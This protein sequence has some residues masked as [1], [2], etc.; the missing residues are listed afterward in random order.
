MNAKIKSISIENFKGAKKA[1][2]TFGDKT[3]IFGANAT[4]K[5]TIADAVWWLLFNKDSQ[6]NEKFSIRPLDSGGKQ[7]DNVEI[8]VTA[9]LDI[10]GKEMT[11]R[12][13][14][15]QNWV[16]KRGE[17]EAK[18]QGNVDSYEVDGYPKAEKDYKECV[19]QII[20]E[21]LFKILTSPTYFPNMKWQKQR[22]ILM[23]FVTDISDV[24]LARQD[25]QFSKLI[26]E[27]EKAPSTDDIKKKYQKSL[28]E[29]K[30]KQK[31]LPVRIDEAEKQKVDIDIAELELLKNSLNEQIAK[32]KASQEDISKQFEEQQKA[33]DGV[34]ELRF[35]LSDLVRK[36]NE[37]LFKKR[38]ELQS[39]IDEKNQ[40]LFDIRNGIQKNDR[41]IA[42]YEQDIE[43]GEKER[44]RLLEEWQRVKE[45]K[46]DENTAICPTCHRELPQEERASLLSA[47][48]KSKTE[49][50]AKIEKDGLEIKA[51]IENAKAMIPKLRNC[52]KENLANKEKLEKEVADLENRMKE[53][54][55]KADVSEDEEIKE[56]TQQIAEKEAAMNQSGTADEMREQIKA[57]GEDLQK[58]LIEVEKQLANAENNAK[59]DERIIELQAEQRE[60]AQKVA[61]QEKMLYLLEDF[62]RFK[63]DKVSDTIN[64][65]L[66]GICVKLFENQINGGIKECC[67]LTYDGVP[68]GSLNNGHRIVAGLKII[69]ALQELYGVYAPIFIDNAESVNDFNLPD[70]D[71]QMIFLSVPQLTQ[72][73]RLRMSPEEINEFYE[74]YKELRVEVG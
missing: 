27:L 24:E 35:K 67:E 10:D 31:E 43:S 32:N 29:W 68:Y 2:Y 55:E 25:E 56:I 62:I 9:V 72:F 46:F 58:Q 44:K 26:E 33:S 50:I 65:K 59:L 63:M 51:D 14:Q 22:S 7:I 28:S 17:S 57:D 23:R 64:S 6:G 1:E 47:F 41:E 48:V 8:S 74:Y 39:Q 73:Q 42:G 18:L 45:E 4:G 69:K 21:D 34:M 12:K 13:V 30:E 11:L 66:D 71:C 19:A 52:N 49:R 3:I 38:R 40:H 36:A 70:M 54:P 60:V 61:D 15:K 37:E 5:T 20:G 16:K 53:L